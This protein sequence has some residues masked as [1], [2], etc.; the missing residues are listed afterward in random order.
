MTMPNKHPKTTEPGCSPQRLVGPRDMN[1][2]RANSSQPQRKRSTRLRARRPQSCRKSSSLP[3]PSE[4]KD[5][6]TGRGNLRPCEKSES[7]PLG[8][9]EAWL[10]KIQGAFYSYFVGRKVVGIWFENGVKV[11]GFKF[12]KGPDVFIEAIIVNR[13]KYCGIAACKWPNDQ[14][15]ARREPERT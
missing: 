11:I 3:L 5:T 9:S 6:T 1:A 8:S 13:N 10:R 7:A 2:N 15:H 12:D 14:A 4:L